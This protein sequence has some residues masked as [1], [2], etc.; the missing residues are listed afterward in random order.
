MQKDGGVIK[1]LLVAGKGWEL[2]QKDDKVFGK[3]P[4]IAKSPGCF[5]PNNLHFELLCCD[6]DVSVILSALHRH[7]S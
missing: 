2:P 3:L 7:S 4:P 1:K 5:C 6:P